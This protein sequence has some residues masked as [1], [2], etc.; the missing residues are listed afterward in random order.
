MQAKWF[1]IRRLRSRQNKIKSHPADSKKL[2]WPVLLFLIALLVPWAIFIGPVRL[3]VYRFV[4]LVMI[5]PCLGMWIAGKAGRIRTVDIILLLFSFWC[6][7][8]LFVIHGWISVQ[9]SGIGFIETLGPYLLARCYIRDADDFYN[10]IQL[11]FRIVL[12]LLPFAIVEFITGHDIWRGLF[13]AIGPVHMDQ[14]M[15]P[16]GGLT[17]VQMGFRPSN[18]IWDV[19]RQYSCAGSPGLGLPKG[20]LSAFFQDRDR[21]SGLVMSLSAGA[22][23]PI[24]VQGF[25]LS[26]DV[27]ITGDQDPVEN[28]DRAFGLDQSGDLTSCQPIF[29][30]N[31]VSYFLVFDPGSYWYRMLIWDYGVASVLKHPLFG[32]GLNDWER[33]RI[34][35]QALTISGFSWQFATACRRLFSCC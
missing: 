32:I 20:P 30:R 15:P 35:H 1:R 11:Q 28:S 24:V 8:S 13:E 19:H 10:L 7:L 12:F 23:V 14:Q 17:R 16:R 3:S 26:C 33:G 5:L 34:C 25:L 4:L 6:T 21:R 22:L 18:P 29:A 27:L 9:T 2:P 31:I